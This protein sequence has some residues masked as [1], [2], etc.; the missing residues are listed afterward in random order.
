MII[1][2]IYYLLIL[3]WNVINIYPK[4]VLSNGL[5]EN[6]LNTDS[7]NNSLPLNSKNN[8]FFWLWWKISFLFN[9]IKKKNGKNEI[10]YNCKFQTIVLK[11][12]DERKKRIINFSKKMEGVITYI[13]IENSEFDNTR[14]T[15]ENYFS[16]ISLNIY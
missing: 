15:I 1:I 14:V 2:Y 16:V 11:S 10:Q 5:N 13:F 3:H 6:I 12:I 8:W 9:N 4:Y 7:K